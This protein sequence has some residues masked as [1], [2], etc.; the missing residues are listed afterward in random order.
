MSKKICIFNESISKSGGIERVT[1]NLANMWV[2]RGYEVDIL[3]ISDGAPFYLLNEHVR[4]HSLHMMVKMGIKDQMLLFISLIRK[5]R[6]FL[7]HHNYDYLI[8]IWTSRCIVSILASKGL[9]VKVIACEHIAFD[10]TKSY[11]KKLRSMTYPHADAVVSL[12]DID[13]EKY[14]LLNENSFTI[15][16]AIDKDFLDIV[17]DRSQSKIILAV[18]RETP[19]KGFDLLVDVWNKIAEKYPEWKI[20]IVGDNFTNKAY[21]DLVLNKIHQ[22]HLDGSIEVIPETQNIKDEYRKAAFYI[23]SS[24]YEGL[25]MVLLE[26]MAAG[27]PAVSFDCP[28]GPRQIIKDGETGMLVENGNI[29]ALASAMEKMIKDS[30]MR[31]K[32]GGAGEGGYSPEVLRRICFHEVGKIIQSDSLIQYSYRG[33]LGIS[34]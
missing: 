14:K 12:T 34:A 15:P 25:P 20:R 23:M 11:F 4:V 26:A 9:P 1:V 6:N 2:K 13:R 24:R 17:A 28:T 3:T 16:N 19:Q 21:A 22:Y 31:I 30:N 29:D 7:K 10:E 5:V 32:M 18:G 8:A 33:K 27:M